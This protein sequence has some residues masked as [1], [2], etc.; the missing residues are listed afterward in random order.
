[1]T[2]SRI[3]QPLWFETLKPF[4]RVDRE[5]PFEEF[6]FYP[7]EVDIADEIYCGPIPGG[8]QRH[9]PIDISPLLA[10]PI[11]NRYLKKMQEA[12]GHSTSALEIK[13]DYNQKN[14][15]EF[16]TTYDDGD[17]VLIYDEIVKGI[18]ELYGLTESDK[19]FAFTLETLTR[20][21]RGQVA[22][23]LYFNRAEYQE[24][25]WYQ[26]RGRLAFALPLF[27]V[28]ILTGLRLLGTGVV[29]LLLGISTMHHRSMVA[30]QS[31]VTRGW[32]VPSWGTRLLTPKPVWTP[33]AWFN[34][35]GRYPWLLRGS[36]QLLRFIFRPWGWQSRPPSLLTLWNFT[37]GLLSRAGALAVLSLG[38]GGTLYLIDTYAVLFKK[39]EGL[40]L[41]RL[42]NWMELKYRKT[43]DWMSSSQGGSV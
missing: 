11:H 36:G 34:G 23:H 35:P 24:P 33:P 4:P 40:F 2:T 15:Y 8:L 6:E 38:I 16:V 14:I 31:I 3:C 37:A 32:N 19:K 26:R 5:V 17:G 43:R 20:Q 42:G 39:S 41:K 9:Q 25:S 27:G 1:M 7:R 12:K 18:E 10:L 21:I 30:I 29:G 22:M 28:A 13:R